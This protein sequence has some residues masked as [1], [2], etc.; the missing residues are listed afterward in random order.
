MRVS[1]RLINHRSWSSSWRVSFDGLER[2]RTRLVLSVLYDPASEIFA[3]PFMFRSRKTSFRALERQL[4]AVEADLER[5]DPTETRHLV[6]KTEQRLDEALSPPR[7]AF[8]HCVEGGFHLGRRTS[9]IAANVAVLADRGVAYITLAHLFHRGIA[10][11]APALPWLSDAW[12]N[13]IFHQR[14]TGLSK[15]GKVAIRAMYEHGILVDTTHM[16]YDALDQTF[17]LLRELDKESG[18][19][20]TD[21]P[22]IASHAGYRF[23]D[24]QYMLDEKTIERIK[25]R[26]GVIGLILARHQLQDRLGHDD[27]SESTVAV[28][29]RHIDEIFRIT[30]SHRYTCI[31][32]DLDGFVKPTMSGVESAEDLELLVRRLGEVYGDA[33]DDI[34]YRNAERVVRKALSRR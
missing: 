11:N 32:S 20:P 15:R 25:E 9:R 2:A 6:A 24:L 31:G 27:S 23:G 3:V 10:N 18:A 30:K 1:A 28:V 4:S 21:M 33:A 17:D 8:V 13:R 34:L 14:G 12:Y 16:R 26:D 22:V 29:M 19:K 7:M 5:I